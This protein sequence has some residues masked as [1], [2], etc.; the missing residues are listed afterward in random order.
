M[1]KI[2][3]KNIAEIK[4]GFQIRGRETL[5]DSGT[6]K[7]IQMRNIDTSSG[8]IIEDTDFCKVSPSPKHLNKYLLK[9]GTVLLLT[10]GNHNSAT[11]IT[12]KYSDYVAA[13]QFIV[14]D[15]LNKKC[16]PAYLEW[17]LNTNKTKLYFSREATGGNVKAIDKKSAGNLYIELPSLETQK[18]IVIVN[19]LAKREN[20]LLDML[21]EKRKEIVYGYSKQLIKEG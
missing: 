12:K 7:I 4:I 15:N 6:H 11:L 18:K 1:K 10:R 5:V 13:G 3:L 8:I 19:N 20:V 14:L 21:K 9:E 2:Q 16:F 17:Y